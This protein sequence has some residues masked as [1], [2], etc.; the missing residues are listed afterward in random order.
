MAVGPPATGSCHTM[1]TYGVGLWTV[2]GVQGR[3]PVMAS[4]VADPSSGPQTAVRSCHCT[5]APKG[6]GGFCTVGGRM[7]M[8]AAKTS[9]PAGV[10]A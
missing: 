3:V 7:Y 2:L 8:A 9:C 5:S 1:V 4:V 10:L 6:I